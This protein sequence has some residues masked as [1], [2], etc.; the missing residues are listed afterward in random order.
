MNRASKE[1]DYEEAGRLQDLLS[2]LDSF[3]WPAPDSI[4]DSISRDTVAVKDN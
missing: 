4:Q 3:G 2:R 1:T